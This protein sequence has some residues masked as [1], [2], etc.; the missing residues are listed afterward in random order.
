A[1]A[2]VETSSSDRDFQSKDAA[3]RLARASPP[4]LARDSSLPAARP[5]SHAVAQAALQVCR[6]VRSAPRSYRRTTQR[7]SADG[8][9]PRPSASSRP[10][11]SRA[12]P[13]RLENPASET[14]SP[15]SEFETRARAPSA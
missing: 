11:P 8:R 9:A 14:A 3:L 12:P 4:L 1:S 13:P 6:L 7:S 15:R 2:A 10:G 5:L